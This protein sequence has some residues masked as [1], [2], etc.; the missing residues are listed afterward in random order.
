VVGWRNDAF[1]RAVARIRAARAAAR[2]DR[3]RRLGLF[4]ARAAREIGALAALNQVTATSRRRSRS[5]RGG[6]A[7]SRIRRADDG[8]PEPIVERHR[9]ELAEADAVLAPSDYV[10]DTLVARGVAGFARRE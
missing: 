4:A 7:P 2:G 8:L 1:D 6:Q 9:R 10:R 3:P 5:S